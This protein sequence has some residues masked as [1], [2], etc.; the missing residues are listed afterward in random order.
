MNYNHDRNARQIVIGAASKNGEAKKSEGEK[1]L[2]EY[3]L[4]TREKDYALKSSITDSFTC[5][6]LKLQES[7]RI[8][9]SS[10]SCTRGNNVKKVSAPT[11]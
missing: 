6:E 11:H 2:N 3:S 10:V 5:N 8:G 7:R 1:E 9:R 4:S